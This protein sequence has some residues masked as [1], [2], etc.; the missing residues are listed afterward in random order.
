MQR[1]AYLCVVR[2]G[3]GGST[4]AGEGTQRN[5]HVEVL[6]LGK[7]WFTW[8]YVNVY[9]I[10]QSLRASRTRTTRKQQIEAISGRG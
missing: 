8:L 4:P 10:I 2:R 9:A 1:T 3:A 6:R 7:K 5:S